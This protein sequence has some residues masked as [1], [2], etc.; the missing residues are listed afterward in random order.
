MQNSNEA[1]K[2]HI[3]LDYKTVHKSTLH[4]DFNKDILTENRIH[5]LFKIYPHFLP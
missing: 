5:V 1:L 3:S 2:K 4:S